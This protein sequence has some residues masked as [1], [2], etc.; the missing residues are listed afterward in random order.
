MRRFQKICASDLWDDGTAAAAD[1]QGNSACN[2]TKVQ[3]HAKSNL[4][5]VRDHENCITETM[6]ILR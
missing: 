4:P 1:G 3:N 6:L 2:W 5:K